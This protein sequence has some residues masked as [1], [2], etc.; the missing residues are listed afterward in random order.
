MTSSEGHEAG[1]QDA[2]HKKGI[3]IEERRLISDHVHTSSLFHPSMEW[4]RR[5]EY[6]K[7]QGAEGKRP[8]PTA[9]FLND[10]V[11]KD[12]MI[13]NRFEHTIRRPPALLA[14]SDVTIPTVRINAILDR[15][16]WA[17]KW[18]RFMDKLSYISSK[19]MKIWL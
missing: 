15:E 5:F 19:L 9:N 12:L 8:G 18:K 13:Y 10:A 2:G 6:I 4:R 1:F 7:E 3:K 14:V 17:V 16:N 11:F